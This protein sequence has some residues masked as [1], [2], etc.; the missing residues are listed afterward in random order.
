[1]KRKG[2][3]FIESPHPAGLDMADQGWVVGSGHLARFFKRPSCGSKL[4]DFWAFAVRMAIQTSGRAQ[5]DASTDFKEETGKP[6]R[7]AG[8]TPWCGRDA[9]VGASCPAP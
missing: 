2:G 8:R 3:S 4:R 7:D 6:S 1:M 9:T 5:Q